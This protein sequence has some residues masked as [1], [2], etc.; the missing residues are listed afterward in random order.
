MSTMDLSIAQKGGHCGN[1]Q[2]S[3]EILQQF[4]M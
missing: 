3:I 4:Q 2:L 1:S